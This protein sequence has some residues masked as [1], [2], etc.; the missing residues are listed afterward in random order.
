M[1]AGSKVLKL[2]D[3]LTIDEAVKQ[4]SLELN[5]TVSKAD[6]YRLALDGKLIL[7]AYFPSGA[8]VRRGKVVDYELA[9]KREVLGL[10]LKETVILSKAFLI[11]NVFN[12]YPFQPAL[13]LEDEIYEIGSEAVWDLAMVGTERCEI[14]NAYL[15]E[16]SELGDDSHFIDGT[17]LRAGDEWLSLQSMLYK[18]RPKDGYYPGS[19][20][21]FD[22]LLVI[23]KSALDNLI[24]LLNGDQLRAGRPSALSKNQVLEIKKIHKDNPKL[25][26]AEIGSIYGVSDSTIKKRWN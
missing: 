10:G 18:N 17:F 23:K 9:E 24:N 22:H 13:L 12:E 16:V 14:H 5:E 4:L 21:D 26:A 2:R 3:W 8:T 11:G 6:I 19:L 20:S 1:T 7:S 15:K 25:T